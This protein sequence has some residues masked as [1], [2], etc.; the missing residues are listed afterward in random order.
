MADNEISP[1]KP[2]AENSSRDAERTRADD[3]VTRAQAQD[4]RTSPPLPPRPLPASHQEKTLLRQ[5][6]LPPRPLV[7]F[8]PLPIEQPQIPSQTEPPINPRWRKTKW[9]FLLLSLPVSASIVGVGLALGYLNAPYAPW[10]QDSPTDWGFGFSASAVCFES[11]PFA[12]F[13]VAEA[14]YA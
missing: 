10:H 8:D 5:A 6:A 1:A 4:S 3:G 2:R 14:N 11:L 13:K 12:L 9:G 7:H